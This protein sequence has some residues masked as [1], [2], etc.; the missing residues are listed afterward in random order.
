MSCPSPAPSGPLA[1]VPRRGDRWGPGRRKFPAPLAECRRRGRTFVQERRHLRQDATDA[2]LALW[3]LLRA[4]ELAGFKSG[5]SIPFGPYI[6]DFYCAC[7][8]LIVELDS[9]QH[10]TPGRRRSTTSAGLL[11][12]RGWGCACFG[13]P[14][15]L[16]FWSQRWC[17]RRSGRRWPGTPHPSPLPG[18]PRQ[19]TRRGRLEVTRGRGPLTLALSPADRGEGTGP[20]TPGRRWGRGPLTQPSPRRTGARGPDGERTGLR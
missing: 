4:R 19:R 1:P 20:E 2:E 12:S 11:S 5:G 7:R 6:V 15:T 8:R 3:R 17:W 13:F 16:C 18:R 14:T 9:E 10:Y